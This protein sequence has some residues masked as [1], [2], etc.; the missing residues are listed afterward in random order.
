MVQRI[1]AATASRMY[2]SP[3]CEDSGGGARCTLKATELAIA[4]RDREFRTAHV[5]VCRG[6]RDPDDAWGQ[7]LAAL[8][9]GPEAEPGTQILESALVMQQLAVGLA[10]D[11]GDLQLAANW[12][13]AN[14]RWLDWSGAVLMRSEYHTLLGRYHR[15]PANCS[16]AA[17]TAAPHL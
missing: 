15:S 17:S 1:L 16:R 7:V 5:A 11:A 2:P 6:R 4:V 8:P 13:A 10:L 3:C 14:E 12:L 9:G